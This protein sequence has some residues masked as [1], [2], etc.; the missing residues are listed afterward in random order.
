MTII[1]EKKTCANIRWHLWND[2][3]LNL[4]LMHC[5]FVDVTVFSST[6]QYSACCFLST[7]VKVRYMKF[8]MSGA[9]CTLWTFFTS[10]NFA[11]DIGRRQVFRLYNSFISANLRSRLCKLKFFSW[12]I[13]NVFLFAFYRKLKKRW[14][15]T[16]RRFGNF[17]LKHS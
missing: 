13:R 6:Y 3:K 17:F 12:A 8:L 15:T 5:G 2:A 10:V 9:F 4:P 14:I 7:A 1:R 16:F 11:V